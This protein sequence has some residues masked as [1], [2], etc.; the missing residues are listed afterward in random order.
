MYGLDFFWKRYKNNFRNKLNE[1]KIFLKKNKTPYLREIDFKELALRA[2]I[3]SLIDK[4]RAE[5]PADLGLVI[6]LSKQTA[7]ISSNDATVEPKLEALGKSGVWF[8]G[9]GKLNRY[10]FSLTLSELSSGKSPALVDL[11]LK[12]CLISH[13]WIEIK[14]KINVHKMEYK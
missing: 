4:S 5:R 7:D 12:F 10:E 8:A 6:E 13:K 2:K 1:I 3:D 14:I 9:G 11:T